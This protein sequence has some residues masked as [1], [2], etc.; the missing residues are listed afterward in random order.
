MEALEAFRG[1]SYKES[2]TL[3]EINGL[4]YGHIPFGGIGKSGK[5]M[6]AHGLIE[7]CPDLRS[8]PKAFYG[9][10]DVSIFPTDYQAYSV[11]SLDDI[12]PGSIAFLDDVARLFPSRDSRDTTLQRFMGLISHKDIL[13]I[14]T[15]QSFKNADVSFYKD[16]TVI[17][18]MKVFS[19]FGILF[20][21]EEFVLFC[22]AANQ[23][24][25]EFER[26]LNVDRH[27]L[28]FCPLCPEVLA[29]GPPP[30]Y[31]FRHSHSMRNAKV[32]DGVKSRG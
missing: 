14:S 5:T 7:A 31:D 12:E 16:Q 19:P 29:I 2:P 24:I 13:I 28:V 27:L 17:P 4:G 22:E 21:R 8:R 1:G 18:M 11:S 26:T 30:W 15:V 20:E 23:L 25:P 9:L 6:N 32:L 3:T 10:P